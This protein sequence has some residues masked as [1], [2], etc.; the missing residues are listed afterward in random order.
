[1]P[2][3]SYVWL[4]RASILSFEELRRLVAVFS[5]LGVEKVRF[6]GGEPLLRTDFPDLVAQVATISGIRDLAMTT[7]GVLLDRWAG[8][9]REAGLRRVTVS[10]DTLRPD[11]FQQFTKSARHADVLRG[12]E[13]ARAAGFDDLK[14]NT[15][16]T[17]G[18][19]D[20]EIEDLVRFAAERHAEIRFIEYMDV[21]GATGWSMD[22]VVP[23]R[24]ILGRLAAAFGSAEP[25]GERGA[26]PAQR[27]RLGDGTVV[28]VIAS[29]TEPFCR[30]CD[31]ARITAD[32]MW[33]RCLYA[34]E[35][36]DAKA[37][38]RSGASD[39][40]IAAAL[41][42]AWEARD[43]RGAE[44]RA[45]LRDREILYP[46]DSLRKDPHLEMHTRGG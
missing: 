40:E 20:D 25:L 18:Q 10:V 37:L 11:R 45:A 1:M 19:N 39:A 32:G 4:A 23:K 41:G 15:V 22:R 17:R 43:D 14:L 36:T 29:T 44:A 8:A 5:M 34:Q 16:V 46:V 13:A 24:E 9:L 28:G 42:E 21:G 2:E 7:N 35:G 30:D 27:F 12:I 6:T 33:Y 26:A 31:R 38:L 3:E